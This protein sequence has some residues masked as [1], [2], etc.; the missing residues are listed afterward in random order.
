M[1]AEA[2]D[3]N[4]NIP[5]QTE[6]IIVRL[7]FGLVSGVSSGHVLFGNEG[8][9]K[10]VLKNSKQMLTPGSRKYSVPHP[11]PDPTRF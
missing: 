4:R 8:K 10:G 5:E 7:G 6:S 3:H 2:A 11:G 9:I 1:D